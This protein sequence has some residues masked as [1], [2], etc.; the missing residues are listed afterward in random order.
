MNESDSEIINSILRSA[1]Y[2]HTPD[3][4]RANIVLLNTCAIRENAESKIWGR[5]NELK[6]IKTK[7]KKKA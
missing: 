7:T 2:L 5:L 1:G 3:I 4:S 6:A